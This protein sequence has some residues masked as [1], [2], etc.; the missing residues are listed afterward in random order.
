MI[1]LMR[2]KRGIGMFAVAG[3]GL[4]VASSAAANTDEDAFVL[5]FEGLGVLTTIDDTTG[6]VEGVGNFY[7]G[8]LGAGGSG[9]GANF[10]VTF[11]DNAL[12][13]VDA[14]ANEGIDPGAG[15]FGGEPSPDTALFFLEGDAATITLADGFT[16]GFSFFYASPFF[17]GSI[18]VYSGVNGTG[19]ILAT[20]DLPTTPENGAPDPNGTASPFVA[21]GVEFDGLARSIDFGGTE[22]QIGFDNI[23]FGSAVALI[24]NTGDPDDGGNG[25]GDGGNGGNGTPNV[26]PTPAALPAGLML[27]SL[28]G[29][30]RRR[31]A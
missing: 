31:G 11:S 25:D 3:L 20:L 21:I 26:I 4:G 28:L 6:F 17:G 19:D 16:D 13:I 9:P 5:D 27:L 22:N 15:D 2:K 8:G 10:G 24:G 23:T 1:S 7:N 14:D 12:A 30:R 29:T 18:D